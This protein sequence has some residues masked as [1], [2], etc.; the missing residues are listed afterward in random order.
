MQIIIPMA[1]RGKRFERAG[2]TIPKPLIEIDGKPMI[3]QVLDLFP[4]E[5]DPLLLC[6][7]EHLA[8]SPLRETV[9]AL[10][11]SATVAGIKTHTLGPVPTI[12]EVEPFIKDDEPIIV[13]Y[14]DYGTRW[15]YQAFKE[16]TAQSNDAGIIV[17]YRGFHPHLLGP[18]FYAGVRADRQGRVLE[19]R[20]KHS[21]TKNKM[22]CW[23]SCGLYYFQSGSLLKTY[24]REYREHGEKVNGEYFV[25]MVY[26]LIL[27]D[28][29]P[30]SVYPIDFFAQWGTPEDLAEY[31]YWSKGLH[32]VRTS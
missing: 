9:L 21:F 14:C 28:Q 20:E 19:I 4:G 11:P 16:H 30:V 24:C 25:S 32:P 13:S 1:G 22:D 2:F 7:E 23:Q 15:S 8:A 31:L 3:A 18:N 26:D 6:N 17:C 10:R 27:K 12:L 29:Q 5:E